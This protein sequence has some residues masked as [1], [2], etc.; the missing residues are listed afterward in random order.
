[1]FQGPGGRT[2]NSFPGGRGGPRP[3]GRPPLTSRGPKR[4]GPPRKRSK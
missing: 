1:M 2:N 4:Q 3:A